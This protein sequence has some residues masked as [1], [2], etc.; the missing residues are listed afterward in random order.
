MLSV[1]SIPIGARVFPFLIM[2]S[3]IASS[4]I[5]ASSLLITADVNWIGKTNDSVEIRF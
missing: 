4:V 3:F 2:F 1:I 5:A